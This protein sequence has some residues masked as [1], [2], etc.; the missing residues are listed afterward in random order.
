M[1]NKLPAYLDI[2]DLTSEA[3]ACSHQMQRR[4]EFGLMLLDQFENAWEAGFDLAAA[5]RRAGV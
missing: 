4:A 1:T 5:L 2:P 3:A